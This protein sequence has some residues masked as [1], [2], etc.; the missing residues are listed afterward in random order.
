MTLEFPRS[1]LARLVL[2]AFLA[3]LVQGYHL[4]VDDAEI[5]VPAIKHAADPSLYPF[6]SEFFMSHAR[7]S[8]FPELVGVSARL[9]HLPIDFV[10]FSWQVACIFLLLL[11][12]WQLL[13]A[14][15]TNSAARW[16]GVALLAGTLSVPVAGTALVIMDPYLTARSLSTPATIFAIACWV[17]NRRMQAGA[18]LILTVLVHPQMGVYGAVFIGCLWLSDHW[19]RGRLPLHENA[20]VDAEAVPVLTLLAG[21]PF[22]FQLQPDRGAAREALLSR[23]YFFVSNWAWYEWIGVFAPLAMV[24]WWSS[25]R[26]HGTTPVFRSLLRTLVPFGLLFTVA[27]LVLAS[28]RQL[29][30]FARLQP[31]RAFHL[32]YV[33]FF[34]M[35]GGLMGEY[36]LRRNTWR[37]RAVFVP[38]A[39][40]M[41]LLQF[42]QFPSS[43]HVEWPGYGYHNCWNSA[44]FWIRQHT[45]TDAVFALDPNYMKIEGEDQHGFRAVAERSA[46]ADAVKDSGAVSLFPHLADHWKRQ[47]DA[48]HGWERFDRRDFEHLA[49]LYPVTWVL[50]R[51]PGP[52][53]LMCPYQ[54]EGLSVCRID[55]RGPASPVD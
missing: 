20:D 38:L 24:W 23:A 36:V 34:A 41:C 2:I 31:M 54:N 1:T 8:L 11:A 32:I 25:V 10:I 46:L 28:S 53:G 4:G 30:N 52:A 19:S 43:A 29:E 17:S 18:W 13:S 35:L 37:W 3:V 21:L 5:Y 55:V 15:F 48:Q 44:F 50:L 40:S 45:P 47:V 51:S 12:S 6:G 49:K 16:S 33:I 42:C 9:T 39:G 14:C 22:L 7:W 27:G 26:L